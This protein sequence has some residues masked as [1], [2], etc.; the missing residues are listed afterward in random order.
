[1][2]FGR[3][4][5]ELE[6]RIEDVEQQQALEKRRRKMQKAID[7]WNELGYIGTPNPDSDATELFMNFPN[8]YHVKLRSIELLVITRYLEY[9]ER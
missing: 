2:M 9:A 5:K 3:K 1:M 7:A 6:K 8:G 4:Q